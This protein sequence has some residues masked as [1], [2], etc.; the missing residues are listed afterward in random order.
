[1]ITIC[2]VLPQQDSPSGPKDGSKSR[3][4]TSRKKDESHPRFA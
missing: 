4:T 1:M 2:T 3:N